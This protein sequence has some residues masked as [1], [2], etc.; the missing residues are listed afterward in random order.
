MDIAYL[1]MDA[2]G[3]QQFVGGVSWEERHKHVLENIYIYSHF[4]VYVKLD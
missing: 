1:Q 3:P 2:D 4:P